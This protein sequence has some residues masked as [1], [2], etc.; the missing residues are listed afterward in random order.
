MSRKKV[1]AEASATAIGELLQRIRQI[2]ESARSQAARS[3]NSALVQANWLIGRQ[4]VEA[5]QGGKSRAAYSSRL[6]ETLS[7]SL[8]KEYGSGFSVTALKYMRMFYLDYPELLEIRHAV[9]DE[10]ESASAE[11]KGPAVRDFSATAAETGWQPGRLH[12]GLSWTHYRTLLK[13]ERREARDFYEIEAIRNG[14]SARQLERQIN[15]FLFDR[16]LKSRDKA[17]VLALANEGLLPVRPLDA[18][19]DPYVLEFLDLPESHRLVE[20]RIEEALISRLQ[21]FLLELGSGFAF[22]GRQVRLTLDG[23]HFYPDLVFYHVKLKC[24]VVIDL[25]V[26]RLTH[27]DLGQMLMY[28]NYYDREIAAPDDQPTIGLILCAGKNDAMVRYVLADKTEQIFA[29][30]YQF[31]LPSEEVLRAKLRR[32]LDELQ[33]PG[34]DS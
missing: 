17:G 9:R 11:A 19:K 1:T 23:D 14:W 20:S 34:A 28:V 32:E 18:I 31:Q 26:D 6:L 10:L 2:W 8:E 12:A 29:S 21:D 5:E 16:L 30:R 27:G 4:I 7:E 25:K 15:T 3:V 33:G 13:I 24:Y 22:I